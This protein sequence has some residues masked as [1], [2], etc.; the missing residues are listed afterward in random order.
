MYIGLDVHSKFT[1]YAAQDARGK[2]LAEGKVPTTPEELHGVLLKLQA[3]PGTV[4]GLETGG[5][6]TWVS[7]LL[8][9]WGMAPW[10][11]E[12]G[13]VRSKALRANQKSDLRDARE[14]CQGVR[15]AIYQTRV[16]IPDA[17]VERL[18][19]L[20]SRRRHFVGISTRQINS[21]KHLLRSRGWGSLLGSVHARSGWDR[22]LRRP[23]VAEW[24]DL[25]ALHADQWSL[26]QQ[27][28]K[29]IERELLETARP[30][31][32]VMRLLQT[33]MGV[34][35]IVAATFIAALGDP[36]RFPD[37]GRVISYA[38]LAVSTYNSG[39]RQMH[40][41]I[42]K[43]GNSE[44]RAMLCEAAQHAWRP[45]HP[46]NPYYR[47]VFARQGR[48]QAVIAVAQRMARILWRIWLHNEPFNV[49]KLNVR[50][51]TKTKAVSVRYEIKH[52]PEV[53]AMT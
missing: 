35:P 7:R 40:G 6:S 12:A 15:R 31:E 18:R 26:A 20:I 45:H 23:E 51:V 53:H 36:H 44:L 11:I 27:S 50:T 30:L 39:G 21:V 5:Q 16:Y 41:H 25:I 3:P 34:G 42:T 47:R 8:T 38:G 29:A 32:S 28:R 14:I 46:L 37:S 24:K 19:L 17:T 49:E 9:Q 48:K 10:V 13:E 1:V 52:K 2:S 22:L 33:M 4:V 43:R